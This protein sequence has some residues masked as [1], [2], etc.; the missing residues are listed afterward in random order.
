MPWNFTGT[1]QQGAT[2]TANVPLAYDD[3][4]ANP[5]VHTYHPDH[6]NLDP[7]FGTQQ[8]R[9]LESYGVVRQLTLT[10]TAPADNFNSLTRGSGDLSGNYAETITFQGRGTQTRQYNVLGSF[11]LKRLSDIATLTAQ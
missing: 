2:L 7:L 1:L 10:I 6:D 5:F 8:A 3:Q 4:A 11:S 9:G